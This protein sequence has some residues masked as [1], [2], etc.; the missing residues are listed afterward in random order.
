M[1]SQ[2]FEVQIQPRKGLSL[3]VAKAHLVANDPMIAII[4][5]GRE[6]AFVDVSDVR[7]IHEYLPPWLEPSAS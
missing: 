3:Y 7:G 2:F 5:H 6:V 4:R 1:L